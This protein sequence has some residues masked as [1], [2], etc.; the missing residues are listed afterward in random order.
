MATYFK[1]INCYPG[2]SS[3]VGDR[4]LLHATFIV[5]HKPIYYPCSYVFQSKAYQY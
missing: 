5:R 4:H 3:N 1:C 2:H